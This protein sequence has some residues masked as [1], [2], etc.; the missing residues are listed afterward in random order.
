MKPRIHRLFP[1]A[2]ALLLFLFGGCG[3]SDQGPSLSTI[4]RYPNATQGESIA[5][6]SLGGLISGGLVQLTTTDSFDQV[7]A[8]YRGELQHLNPQLM[9]HTTE[10]GR[11]LAITLPREDGMITVAL[12]EFTAE[13]TV[14]ITL[15]G[16]DG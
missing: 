5:Q 16:M 10:L 3:A 8:F 6:S 12:Q 11:Q 1:L 15:M 13:G 4:P 9:S 14:N 2:I 7:V